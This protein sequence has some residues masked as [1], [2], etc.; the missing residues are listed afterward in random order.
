MS[1]RLKWIL[2]NRREKRE[3]KYL[4]TLHAMWVNLTINNI[5]GRS[6]RKIKFTVIEKSKSYFG[7]SL[8]KTENN[9]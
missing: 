5:N 6:Q 7:A 1:N 2:L 8:R 4:I 9:L 3:D